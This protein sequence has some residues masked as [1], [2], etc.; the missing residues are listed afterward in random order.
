MYLLFKQQQIKRNAYKEQF[1]GSVEW[2]LTQGNT[3]IVTLLRDTCL[4][5]EF[6]WRR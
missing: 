5:L 2:W 3:I 1:L 4:S 6:I